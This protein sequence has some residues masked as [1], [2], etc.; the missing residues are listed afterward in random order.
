MSKLIMWN[1]LTLDGLFEGKEKWSLDFH[2]TVW[3]D[4]LEEFSISQLNA[5]SAL[6]FG[7][8]TYE[9]MAKYWTMATGEIADHMNAI[10]KL[11]ASTTLDRAD[12][13]NS[14]I[15]RNDVVDG[16]RRFKEDAEKD[17]YLFGSADLA[18]TLIKAGL[19]DEY[20]LCLAPTV[21]GNGTPLFKSADDSTRMRLVNTRPL[22]TGGIILWYEP[23]AS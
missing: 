22:K 8:I 7:R 10:P 20:R 13:N 12:W 6:L 18:S 16:I 4:E 2:E 5:A 14:R 19:I 21:L 9:G 23:L 3:G 11:V 17:V 1:L 15:I